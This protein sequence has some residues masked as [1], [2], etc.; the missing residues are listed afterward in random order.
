MTEH[1]QI[2]DIA[3]RIQY[4]G[5]GSTT[6]F[7]YPFP[8]F[9]D[10]DLEVHLDQAKQASGFTVAG[11]GSSSG[12]TVTFESAPTNGVVVTLLRNVTIQ[13]TSDFQ[14]SGEFR[15][16][17]INDELDTITAALQ[18][19][20]AEMDRVPRLT[21][22]DTT[23]APLALPELSARAN[24][25]FHFDATGLPKMVPP[26]D[27]SADTVIAA[28]G[29]A[30][31]SHSARADDRPTVLDWDGDDTT[32]FQK[33]LDSGAGAIWVPYR[34][35]PYEIG[36]LVVPSYAVLV[37]DT[38]PGYIDDAA[39]QRPKLVAGAGA[40]DI[41]N[42]DGKTDIRIRG[43]WLDG[44]GGGANGIGGDVY[45]LQV[46]WTT[47]RRCARGIG[48][49]GDYLRNF[50][51]A[52][53]TIGGCSVAA[54]INPIDSHIALSELNANTK[55]VYCG[56]GANNNT[57]TSVRLEWNTQY[58]LD[59]DGAK[60]QI[61]NACT[62]DS[63]YRAGLR[64][65][66]FAMVQVNGG[67]FTR[68]GRNAIGGEDCHILVDGSTGDGLDLNGVQTES[69]EDDGGGGGFRPDYVVRWLGTA[70]GSNVVGGDMSGFLTAFDVGGRPS[71][72]RSLRARGLDD[73]NTHFHAN[74]GGTDQTA[75]PDN[76]W[77]KVTFGT[78][79]Y[80]EGGSYDP[81]TSRFTPPA[82][83]WLIAANVHWKTSV[84]LKVFDIALYKNG[85]VHRRG[86]TAHASG[87]GSLSVS[88]PGSP[89]RANGT[90][91]YEIYVRQ[92]SGTTLDIDGSAEMTW[93]SAAKVGV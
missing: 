1:I 21:P 23:S 54:I 49:P 80:D 6:Q 34:S 9:A 87:G 68:N 25:A 40:T 67:L 74:K 81:V 86:G 82:G 27:V 15:A 69:G 4:T 71:D 22:T 91:Y 16:K 18:E 39:G 77:T 57:F 60:K 14:E 89:D 66:N 47:I 33:A 62:F 8:I 64:L 17:V 83:A 2:G 56:S 38:P 24:A 65:D 26:S 75:V 73:T 93:F 59:V 31:R 61:L 12:G 72:F 92:A 50:R 55:G 7:T 43:L 88:L 13:R 79:G 44:E 46:G 63:N 45:R 19:L 85:V 32:R 30:S 41:L 76:T 70:T 36:D 90:D 37:G 35:T 58:G 11:A 42:V 53:L 5:N 20:H 28:S 10:A 84:D 78:E 52:W 3:P 29:D 48:K 51:G